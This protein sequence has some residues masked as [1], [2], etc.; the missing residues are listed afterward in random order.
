MLPFELEFSYESLLLPAFRTHT[1]MRYA[2]DGVDGVQVKV[3]PVLQLLTTVQAPSNTH[4]L[5]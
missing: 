2:P 3:L 5:Y 1:A 4:H